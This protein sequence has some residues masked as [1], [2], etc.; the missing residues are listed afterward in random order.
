M[1]LRRISFAKTIALLLFP[2]MNLLFMHYYIYLNHYI[3]DVVLLYNF[4]TNFLS[5]LFDVNLL[6]LLFLLFTMGKMELSL[7]LTYF[8]SLLWSFVNVFYSR[9]FSHYITLSVI[10]QASN[11]T[12]QAV[13]NSMMSG[14]H[15]IDLF[16][17]LSL[18]CFILVYLRIKPLKT[19]NAI[20]WISLLTLMISMF[21]IS[22]TYSAYHILKSD[23]RGNWVL[24]KSRIRGLYLGESRNAFPNSTRFALGSTRVLLG[25]LYDRF[26]SLELSSEQRMSI[27]SEVADLSERVTR[28][29]PNQGVENVVFV[30]LES[31]LSM[32]IDLKVD[33][34]EITPFLNALKNDT[35]V[36]YNGHV[37]PNITMGESGD[38]QFVFMTGILPLRDR[39]T[40]GEAKE[41]ALPALPRLLS[42]KCGIQYTEIV[43]PSPPM[44][45][46]QKLMNKVYGINHMYCNE[47]VM[48]KRYD[49]L[50]DE[51]IFTLAMNTPACKQKPF[52]SMVLSYSTHQPYRTPVDD[53]FTLDAPKDSVSLMN[54]LI[55][56]HYT[57]M[58]LKKY[59][60]YLKSEGVY[61][62]TLIII[63]A[64]HHAHLD[65][66][67]IKDE[68]MKELPL[69]I[70]HG[71]IDNHTAWH[72]IMNQL[73]IFTTIIDLLGIENKWHGL[74][75]TILNPNYK[76]SLTEHA[77]VISE[78]II[79]GR[80]FE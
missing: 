37:T 76:N 27:A 29:A 56:C 6:F 26:H 31:F 64:D 36:Y 3:E 34:K 43:I 48:G 17:P 13:V 73:D 41:Q 20:V 52:F 68:G 8:V 21:A 25:E 69:F 60:D 23:T 65:A 67:G 42:E 45:W 5:V 35:T 66:L 58:W 57:D 47:D 71:D 28:S 54:Y 44:I 15:W 32:P 9:F 70:I 12:D 63:T 1:M 75:H 62:R 50:N 10:S 59:V 14:F 38:G 22:V 40:V 77:W 7:L 80:Y 72:G 51:E 16:F 74:G 2:V 24:Y 79:K 53:S 4:G 78:Q 19:G 55:A 18:V 11:L 46:E 30:V 49:Y 61:D 33:G 39:L